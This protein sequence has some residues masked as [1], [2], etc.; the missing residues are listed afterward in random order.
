MQARG[1]I[2]TVLGLVALSSA[3][4]LPLGTATPQPATTAGKGRYTLGGRAELPT[5]D[6]LETEEG[7]GEYQLTPIPITSFEFGYGLLDG[8]DL[9]VSLDMA[10]YFGVPLPLGGALGLR[11][12]AF[13]NE[14]VAIAMA[15]RLGYTGVSNG[16]SD[17][18]DIN[19]RSVSA[20]YGLGSVST[21][22]NPDGWIRP[23]IAFNY[24]GTSITDDPENAAANTYF[25]NLGSSTVYLDISRGPG[26]FGPFINFILINTDTYGSDVLVT[27]GLFLYGRFGQGVATQA[28][29]PAGPPGGI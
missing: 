11:A 8:L 4:V 17:E 24:Y 18:D 3:C 23:G 12:Q 14:T 28:P 7:D 16:S 1:A 22:L 26:H 19:G 5:I 6:L 9:E 2:V 15:A 20:V 10:L 21:M 29:L 27:G 25:A 13:R